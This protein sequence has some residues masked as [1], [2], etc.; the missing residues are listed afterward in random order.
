MNCCTCL[1]SQ[2]I[3]PASDLAIYITHTSSHTS[4]THVHIL[5]NSQTSFFLSVFGPNLTFR[6]VYEI[7]VRFLCWWNKRSLSRLAAKC[8]YMIHLL[9]LKI[10]PKFSHKQATA[11]FE[12]TL[13]SLVS[14]LSKKKHG[15][16]RRYYPPKIHT[17]MRRKTKFLI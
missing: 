8:L 4:L 5:T 17:L 12:F 15:L 2:K 3:F 11:Q 7:R 14:L 16:E 6:I 13:I 1:G 9:R 10:T